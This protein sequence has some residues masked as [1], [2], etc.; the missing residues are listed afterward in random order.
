[1]ILPAA[2][3]VSIRSVSETRSHPAFESRSAIPIAA[4]RVSG[5]GAVTREIE[6]KLNRLCW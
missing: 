3:V 1:M 5:D 4:I 6:D 2:V